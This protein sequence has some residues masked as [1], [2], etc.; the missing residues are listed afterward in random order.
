[1][2]AG[3]YALAVKQPGLLTSVRNVVE[4]EAALAGGAALI[5]IK[6][7][8]RGALGRAQDDVIADIVRSVAGR[9]PVSAALGELLEGLAL[10]PVGGLSFVKWG[11]AGAAKSDWR[12]ALA[13]L[14]KHSGPK[15]VV[16]AYADWQCALAPPLEEVVAFACQAP[17]NVLLIDTCCKD[18]ARLSLGRRPTLL[19]WLAVDEVAAICGRCRRAGV[20][21]A[22][23]GSLAA[24]QIAMLLPT[25]PDWFAIRGAVCEAGERGGQVQRERVAALAKLMHSHAPV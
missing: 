6:E 8:D 7:P 25:A 15:V 3:D 21:I 4:A 20:R 18:A 2:R 16:V 1:M 13:R 14:Q 22:L 23:A 11:L 17:G 10:P 5:D 12:G 19:D 24:E 9:R